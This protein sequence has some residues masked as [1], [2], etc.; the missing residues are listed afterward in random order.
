MCALKTFVTI[1][2]GTKFCFRKFKFADKKKTLF[3]KKNMNFQIN[4]S[5]ISFIEKEYE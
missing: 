4:I 5:L 1:V 2:I 3:N